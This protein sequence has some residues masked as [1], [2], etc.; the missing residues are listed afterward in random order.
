MIVVWILLGLISY[1]GP[2]VI[3]FYGCGLELKD[4]R[5]IV[6]IG[7]VWNYANEELVGF[8]FIPVVGLFC[9]FYYIFKIIFYK[10][11]DIQI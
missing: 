2:I 7:D 10:I 3:M 4:K 1:I 8:T 11:K 9:G 6:T 5:K